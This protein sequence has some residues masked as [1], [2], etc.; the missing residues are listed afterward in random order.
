MK[1]LEWRSEREFVVDGVQF[2]C[3]IDDYTRKTSGDRLV[4]LK[5]R[6]M[7]EQYAHV[8]AKASPRNMLEFGI[9]QGGSPALFASWLEAEKV[10]GIDICGPI[11]GF[12]AFCRTHPIGKRIRSYYGV[13][14]TDRQRIE[15][16]LE[17]EFGATPIDVI[18]DDA[19]HRYDLTRRTFEI[20]FPLLRPGG[21]YLIEDWGWAHWP[22][23][24]RFDS[25]FGGQTPLS[26]LIME[27]MMLC[28]SRS[29]L[30]SE[31]LVF[32]AFAV[33][34]KSPAA[35]CVPNFRLDE[36]YSKGPIELV[37]TQH[38]NLRGVAR[39]VA[40]RAHR[41]LQRTG[42]KVLKAMKPLLR[43]N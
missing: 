29:D 3:S 39:L 35:E 41:R 12:D 36:A 21:T 40:A 18:I 37:G 33:I 13:S 7:L 31:M 4:L 42:Q 5:G 25:V 26:M 11:P 1:E 17:V 9:F 8:F 23:S 38:L 2:E 43:T 32:P 15:D 20:A 27:L 16:I 30:V 10:V 22:H 6:G 28:A 19:S 34:R 14:Q 24:A